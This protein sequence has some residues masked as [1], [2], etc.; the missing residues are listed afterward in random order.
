MIQ[1]ILPESAVKLLLINPSPSGHHGLVT[2]LE[3]LVSEKS[4][5]RTVC[6][7]GKN[8]VEG[9]SYSLQRKCCQI[10][11]G[12]VQ[13]QG[14]LPPFAGRGIPTRHGDDILCDE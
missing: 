10:P 7:G 4:L 5:G 13:Q 8:V 2:G 6:V 11:L 12:A 3:H 1:V 9:C 14:Q